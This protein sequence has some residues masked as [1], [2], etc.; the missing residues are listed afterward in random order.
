M[1][2]SLRDF[3]TDRP[4]L[5]LD[6]AMGTELHRRGAALPLPLWSAHPLIHAPQLVRAVHADY[7]MAGADILTTDTFR[8]NLRALRRAGM[9]RRWEELN[10]RAV[11][12][13]FEARDRHPESRPILIAAGIAPVEDCYEPG[14][15]PEP[16]ELLEE[17]GR[18]AA[19]LAQSGADFLLFETLGTI[20]E[21]AAAA[22]AG[23]ATGREFCVGFI[24]GSE[25]RLLSGEPLVEA[26]AAVERFQPAALFVNCTPL[27]DIATAL[28][29]LL[30]L[31]SCPVGCYANTVLPDNAPVEDEE[32]GR[33]YA[34][35]ALAWVSAGA[36]IVGGCCGTTPG[37][38][39]RVADAVKPEGQ[40]PAPGEC[41]SGAT[42]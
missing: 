39:R 1:T 28:S 17:H 8:T 29:E 5:V 26:V 25:G 19:L 4:V 34:R 21:A 36:R 33:A 32:A 31:T 3:L 6:G 13:A 41:P 24:C 15:V 40:I 12:L 2:C 11:Q 38:I 14:S 37:V 22:E 20:R 7:A 35:E 9:E 16:P 10:L 18:Q 30:R 23:A 42:A 27:P